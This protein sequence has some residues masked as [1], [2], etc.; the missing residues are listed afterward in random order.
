[1]RRGLV[2]ARRQRRAW[3]VSRLRRQA[4]P[5]FWRCCRGL[6]PRSRFFLLAPF[7]ASISYPRCRAGRCV[8]ETRLRGS[9]LAV[10]ATQL[11]I[12]N[13]FVIEAAQLFDIFEDF[14]NAIGEGVYVLGGAEK[15]LVHEPDGFMICGAIGFRT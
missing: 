3:N 14:L 9:T 2:C 12:A 1:M 4:G 11:L 13:R 10:G 15:H 6:R 8:V 5:S 7:G